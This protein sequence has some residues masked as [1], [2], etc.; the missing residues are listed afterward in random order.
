MIELRELP[1]D[2]YKSFVPNVIINVGEP[3]KGI[4]IPNV[5]MVQRSAFGESRPTL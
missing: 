2:R 5:L 3:K 1:I 4:D